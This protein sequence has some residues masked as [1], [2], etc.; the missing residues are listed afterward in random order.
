[1][2]PSVPTERGEVGQEWRSVSHYCW[3]F[4][5]PA[6]ANAYYHQQMHYYLTQIGRDF[7]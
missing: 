3:T 1:M 4:A 2:T 5:A 7:A 6:N